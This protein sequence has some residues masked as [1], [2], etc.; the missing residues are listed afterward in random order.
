MRRAASCGQPLQLIA[1]PRGAR[2]MRVPT[3]MA[4]V[5]YNVE[6]DAGSAEDQ[7]VRSVRALVKRISKKSFS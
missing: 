5:W 1:G 6:R 2:M 3:V 4:T 7:K